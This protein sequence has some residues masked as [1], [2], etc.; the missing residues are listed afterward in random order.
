MIS[1]A[2]RLLDQLVREGVAAGDEIADDCVVVLADRRVERRGAGDSA[3]L[4]GLLEREVRLD[5]DLVERRLAAEL[6]PELALGAVQLVDALDDVHRHP[7]HPRLVGERPRDRLADP[8]GGVRRELEASAPVEL[9][10][11]ADQAQ[12]PLLDQI[13]ERQALVAVVLR[14]RDDQT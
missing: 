1:A 5:G 10:D 3:H 14:D 9:L 6:G 13:E 7:D 11:G 4:A 12:R 2:E 8:P